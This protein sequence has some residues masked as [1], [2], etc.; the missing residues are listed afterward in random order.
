MSDVTNHGSLGAPGQSGA[1][2]ARRDWRLLLHGPLDGARNMEIDRCLLE[3]TE[4]SVKPVTWFRLYRW[5]RPTV[6]LGRHQKAETAVDLAFCRRAGVGVVTRPT[7]GRAVFHHREL[8]YAVVSNDATCFPQ[9]NIDRTYRQI[10]LALLDGLTRHGVQAELAGTSRPDHGTSPGTGVPCFATA[11]RH[12]ILWRGRKLVGSAQYRLKRSF[13][14]HGSIPLQFD[15]ELMAGAFRLSASQLRT[16]MVALNET[17]SPS[18]RRLELALIEG[19]QSAFQVRL[20][21]AGPVPDF[22]DR[23]PERTPGS[24]ANRLT[25]PHRSRSSGLN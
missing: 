23:N 22:L 2:C 12:E 6:S 19:F 25:Y 5:N 11:S 7:G 8:T 24:F 14:Q 3:W 4:A 9:Q 17:G 1:G 21:P 16:G 18:A 10:A 20:R 13:L 15:W